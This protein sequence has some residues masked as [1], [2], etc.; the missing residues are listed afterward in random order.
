MSMIKR[1]HSET[2]RPSVVSSTKRCSSCGHCDSNSS[3]C[4]KCKGSMVEA[5]IETKTNCVN[6]ICRID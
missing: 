5:T 2:K 1:G 4:P 3:V 6:G